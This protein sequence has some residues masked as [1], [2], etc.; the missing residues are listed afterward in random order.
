M[1][2][3]KKAHPI[4]SKVPLELI[5]RLPDFLLNPDPEIYMS[6]NFVVFDLETNTKARPS[7]TNNPERDHDLFLN[8]GVF[9]RTI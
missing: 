7:P 8:R 6:D 9:L 4:L 1:Q 5:K 3:G 2:R